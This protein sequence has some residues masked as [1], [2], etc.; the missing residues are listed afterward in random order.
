MNLQTINFVT[1]EANILKWISKNKKSILLVGIII[2]IIAGVLD[3]KYQ[4][5][6]YQLLPNSLQT[7]LSDIF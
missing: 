7:Y 4:G 1:V 2:I 6:F 5:L 3:I